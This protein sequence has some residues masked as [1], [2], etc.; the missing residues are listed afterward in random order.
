[1]TQQINRRTVT[2]GIAWSVPAIA[3]AGAAPAFATSHEPTPPDFDWSAGCAT[4]GS[5]GGCA[6]AEKTP[7]VPFTI[8]NNTGQDL[9]FQVLGTKSWTDNGTEPE[10]FATPGGIYTNNGTRDNCNPTVG[11]AGCNGYMSVAIANGETKDLWLVGNQMG[12]ASA[13]WMKVQYRWV[14]ND[15]DCTEVVPAAEASPD[16]I[17]PDNNCA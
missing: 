1:M 9:Q 2:K 8:T 15:R 3:I 7:Q 12:N 6:N 14:T 11:S 10:N 16:K 17:V 13:F 4:T 5:G